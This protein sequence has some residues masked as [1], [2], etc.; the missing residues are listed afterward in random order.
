MQTIAR[1][2]D[3]IPSLANRSITRV[4]FLVPENRRYCPDRARLKRKDTVNTRRLRNL[5]NNVT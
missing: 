4:Q 5:S 3:I 1:D 2:P